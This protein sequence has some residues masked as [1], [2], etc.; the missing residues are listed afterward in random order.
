MTCTLMKM[1]RRNK[2]SPA[3]D[4]RDAIR[5]LRQKIRINDDQLR[6]GIITRHEYDRTLME[7]NAALEALEEKYGIR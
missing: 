2:P 7:V 6:L 5:M 4:D 1:W 3:Q